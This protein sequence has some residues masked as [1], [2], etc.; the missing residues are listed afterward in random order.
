M[1]QNLSQ[2]NQWILLDTYFKDKNLRKT[3]NSFLHI[4]N[5]PNS[6]SD[7]EGVYYLQ[8][9][10]KFWYASRESDPLKWIRNRAFENELLK[11]ENITTD[12]FLHEAEQ[13][14]IIKSQVELI[15]EYIS[16][17]NYQKNFIMV[18]CIIIFI[19][20]H[21]LSQMYLQDTQNWWQL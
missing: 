5:F 17:S 20:W 2:K 21:Y 15:N 8:I 9:C 19:Q 12:R 13:P 14:T 1:R 3:L 10:R 11:D 18:L 16:I 4:Y 6:Y 7:E